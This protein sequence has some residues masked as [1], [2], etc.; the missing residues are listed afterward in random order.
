M[1]SAEMMF[2][3]GTAPE[4]IQVDSPKT[5]PAVIDRFWSKVDRSG[6]P[7][8]CSPWTG[9]V[10]KDGYGLFSGAETT[11][12]SRFACILTHGHPPDER[13]QSCHGLTCVT[14][15]CC[16]GKHLRWDTVEGNHADIV[17]AG[18]RPHGSGHYKARL[19]EALAREIW[20]RRGDGPSKVAADLGLSRAAVRHVIDGQN[21][22]HVTAVP[23]APAP[24]ALAV[25]P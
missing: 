7:D 6:G 5:S 8:A 13:M 21:W 3:S 1:R 19:T 11:R 14:R 23:P 22:K 10:D 15:L 20:A 2:I 16:N 24:Q 12:A 9:A 4:K 18:T 17:L 25:Q